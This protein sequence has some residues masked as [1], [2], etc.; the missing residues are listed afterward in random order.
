MLDDT[1]SEVLDGVLTSMYHA[2]PDWVENPHQPI[3]EDL[4]DG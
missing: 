3:D 1:E 2:D 4:P